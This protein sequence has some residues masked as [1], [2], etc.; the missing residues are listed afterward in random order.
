V[1]PSGSQWLV[2]STTDGF[3]DVTNRTPL[4][5]SSEGG[6][7][8]DADDDEQLVAIAAHERLLRSPILS[9]HAGWRWQ[10]QE[11]PGAVSPARGSVA[12]SPG[13]AVAVLAGNG[14]TVV[15]RA[16]S[17]W[18]TLT[19]GTA[20][21][22]RGAD[23]EA[24][25]IAWQGRSGVV[26][27]HGSGGAAMAYRT[28]DGGTQW[29]PVPGTAGGAVTALRAC[30]GAGRFTVPVVDGSGSLRIV[31]APGRP[32]APIDVGT[33]AIALGCA[34]SDYFVI[35]RAGH[36]QVSADGGTTWRD[37]GAAPPGVTALAPTGGGDG[38]A[39]SGGSRPSVWRIDRDGARFTRIPLPGWVATLGGQVGS[40]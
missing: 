1:L 23:Y 26:T 16:G 28:S 21:A 4:G 39:V 17:S 37:Q 33:G 6:L 31:A 2:V 20:L 27:G 25:A 40:D 15:T 8:L 38:F 10:P 30:L 11:L 29:T 32:G 9:A 14:G 19:T 12:V 22:G 5:V 13:S 36:L 35:D 34:G 3:A 24:D 7:S 18:R